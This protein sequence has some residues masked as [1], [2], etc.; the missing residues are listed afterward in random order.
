M[1]YFCSFLNTFLK[2]SVYFTF[3]RHLISDQPQFNCF[4]AT[5]GSVLDSMC[6]VAQRVRVS[7]V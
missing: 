3:T 6:S 7:H 1:R 5:C 4:V 2:S